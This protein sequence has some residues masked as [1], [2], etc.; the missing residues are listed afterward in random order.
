[1][2]GQHDRLRALEVRVARQRR[3]ER[4]GGARDQ[5]LLHAPQSRAK[6]AEPHAASFECRSADGQVFFRHGGC[7]HSVPASP[8]AAASQR[9]AGSTKTGATKSGGSV[10]V[11]SRR[12]DRDEACRQI[13]RAGA[14]GRAGHEHDDDVGTYERNL[15]R[16]PCR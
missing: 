16:D 5:R 7:P 11:S 8:G 1:V 12:I 6:R 9:P 4:L 15:G 13:H 2:V 10:S 3:F 14:I